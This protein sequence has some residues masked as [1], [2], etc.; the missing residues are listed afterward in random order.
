MKTD[1]KTT[2]PRTYWPLAQ[3]VWARLRGIY[4]EPETVF[5]V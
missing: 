3:L 2:A 1:V 5:W 4:R